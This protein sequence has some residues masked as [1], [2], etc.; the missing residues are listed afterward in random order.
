MKGLFWNVRGINREGKIK[1]ICDTIRTLD[2]DFLAFSETKKEDFS[3]QVLDRFSGN[4]CFYWKWSHTK[5]TAGGILVGIKEESLKLVTA[6][7]HNY[8]WRGLADRRCRRVRGVDV[9][10]HSR[11]SPH[12]RRNSQIDAL[13]QKILQI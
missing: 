11:W 5:S 13:Q 10:A 4:V 6:C 8:S 1:C 3:S 9:A 12:A 7:L 2:L